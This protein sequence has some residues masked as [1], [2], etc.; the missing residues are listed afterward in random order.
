MSTAASL[1]MEQS[2]QG[3]VAGSYRDCS[4]TELSDELR[5]R[6]RRWKSSPWLNSPGFAECYS[7]PPAQRVGYFTRPDGAN[8]RVL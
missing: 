3:S 6:S 4:L 5:E 7:H 8:G 2:E 1:S